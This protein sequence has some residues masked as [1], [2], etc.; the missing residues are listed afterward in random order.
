MGFFSRITRPLSNIISGIGSG[1]EDLGGSVKKW[2]GLDFEE[3]DTAQ[4]QISGILLNK[5]SATAKIPIV[6]G[7]RRVG[8]TRVFLHTQG[9]KNSQLYTVLVLSEGQV[10]RISDIEIN[11]EPLNNYGTVT[12]SVNGANYYF[13]VSGVARIAAVVGAWDQV[14]D[15][16]FVTD[17]SSQ[18]LWT[19]EHRLAGVAALLSRYTY[20]AEHLSRMP[21]ATAVV[22]G[23]VY[24]VRSSSYVASANAALVIYDYMKNGVYGEAVPD[25]EINLASFKKA[26][27]DADRVAFNYIGADET[28]RPLDINGV[29]S[30]DKS[31][32]DNIKILLSH[33]RASLPYVAG[34][35][36]LI[37]R[38]QTAASFEFTND[39]IMGDI[40]VAPAN[41]AS[42][43]NRVTV[44]YVDPALFW[45]KSTVTYPIDDA[46]YQQLLSEDNGIEK[47]DEITADMIT[48]KYQ[49]LDFARQYL[50]ESRKS[51][52][53]SFK[54][55][56]S[57]RK[58][59]PGAVVS[60]N[61]AELGSFLFTVEKRVITRDGEYTF[62]LKEY[63]PSTYS[64]IN[65]S[66]IVTGETP[67]LPT[68]YNLPPVTNLTF[69][70]MAYN[71]EFQGV[72]Q[73]E[74]SDSAFV[75][76]YQVQVFN[77]VTAALVWSALVQVD[78]VQVPNF[79]AGT[80]RA[81]I[82]GFSDL[83][84]T[85]LVT[86]EW[87]YSVPVL[88]IVTGLKQ[89]GT[90]DTALS[91][92]WDAI[93]DKQA[94]RDYQ[95]SLINPDSDLVIFTENVLSETITIP[96]SV[97]ET[98]GF[99][100]H[101]EVQVSATNVALSHGPGASLIVDKPAPLAAL[102]VSF[103]PG[104]N[105][106]EVRVLLSSGSKGVQAWLDTALPVPQDADHIVYQGE[107]G[108]FNVLGL[109]E[110]TQ[111]RL[112][113]ACYDA[114][115][116]GVV[117][118]HSVTTL[119]DGVAASIQQL[120]EREL[121]LG[122]DVV[123]LAQLAQENATKAQVN[124]EAV[125]E[126]VLSAAVESARSARVQLAQN[127][128]YYR[129]LNAVVEV[130]PSTGTITNRAYEY[131]NGKFSEAVVLIDGANAAI[132]LQS[133]RI[134]TTETAIESANSQLSVLAGEINQRATFA[135]VNEAVVGAI[136]AVQPSYVTNFYSG[137]DGWEVLA[138]T[139][140]FNPGQYLDLTL[141]DI[142]TA[143][144]YDGAENPVIQLVLSRDVSAVW[145][146]VVQ[147]QTAG[148]GYS[149]E[150]Q[151][152]IDEIN[153][154]GAQYTVTV[155]FS[156]VPDYT[157]NMITGLHIV[158][159]ASVSD[160]FTLHSVQAGKKTAAQIA[161]DGL[162]GR[163]TDAEQS[164]N[165]VTGTL[166]QYV[167]TT[168][169]NANAMTQSSVSNILDSW[170]NTHQVLATLTE[171][172]SAG[173]ISK[174]NAASTWISGADAY[175]KNLASSVMDNGVGQDIIEVKQT[176]DAQAGV[177]SGQVISITQAKHAV[178]DA[179]E[180]L[181]LA[182]VAQASADRGQMMQSDSLALAKQEIKATSDE[183]N[184][185]AVSVSELVAQVAGNQA[186]V[187]EYQRA[188]IGF[189]VDSEGNPTSHETAAACE[190]VAGNTWQTSTIAEAVKNVTITASDTDGNP[191]KVTAGSLYQAIVDAEGH[192]TAT[193][194]LMAALNGQLAGVFANVG[195]S[196]SE[197]V[198]LADR[199]EF[200]T[201]NG[202][203][204]PFQIEGETLTAKDLIVK[205]VNI[206][207]AAIGS[208]Q[209]SDLESTGYIPG[210]EG[211][212]IYKDGS[213]EF[214]GPVISR[215]LSV[216]EGVYDVGNVS[217]SNQSSITKLK[218]V[219]I[220]T[221]YSGVSWAGTS[222]Y[223]TAD[224]G[225][226]SSSVNANVSTLA[227]AKWAVNCEVLPVTRWNAT[228][229]GPTVHL[230]IRIWG[231]RINYINPCKI[232]WRLLRVS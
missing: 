213:A 193:A 150:Y 95:V 134:T 4:T 57:A 56:P 149:S 229:G 28:Y 66:E 159:G 116:L 89:V 5:A 215:E 230:I 47:H 72:L 76:R 113:V 64:W 31:R 189:C 147:Y 111:Y 130:D 75:T 23:R 97:F 188:A 173:T 19:N 185:L 63:D 88:P 55:L 186:S 22:Q 225:F 96:F 125:A 146:G 14:A 78:N 70:P 209:I 9:S 44:T 85:E 152:P 51:L 42:K 201:E 163:V 65:P 80:Y 101:F 204:T 25:D 48:S 184:A 1:L 131:T 169:Y 29:V 71:T 120:T 99:P 219:V 58:V 82:K 38:T 33:A 93:S 107:T 100:R 86:V 132:N 110:L 115:G 137:L 168:W 90:F 142:A 158:L 77:T 140:V 16:D 94:L 177:L 203:L 108:R 175:I 118:N 191:V 84:A 46:E 216:L 161:L 104:H 211:W 15:A 181:L 192:A 155:D 49:A 205:T 83:S 227:E 117:S 212:K 228:Y 166:E 30:T 206:D 91:L 59:L 73:W 39:H 18:G 221:G 53:V 127:D 68:P 160:R 87:A 45:E 34:Q 74:E 36:H 103:L 154:D 6:Y 17:L 61:V 195:V 183:Q 124:Q 62:S 162:Q 106:F 196:G 10:N 218:E 170:N 43:C 190:L 194:A 231:Q 79:P 37:I 208:A 129:I 3:A 148:H 40:S 210:Q 222:F 232:K 114:F 179:E 182:G 217:A 167:T 119:H 151:L 27:D 224:A 12:D 123:T 122:N 98:L 126:A 214:N 138:G 200:K 26:A 92:A 35:Y 54:A 153:A 141:G 226:T 121:S 143:L 198:F 8:G 60:V 20:N 81:E 13:N 50:L 24:D 128:E 171:L 21:V 41:A 156:G 223:I 11:D 207:A 172:N 139:A 7:T 2:L 165:A 174:A 133:Q 176:L 199:F 105:Q 135:Q 202:T 178:N 145:A 157:N 164:I 67:T 197:L 220:D 102:S 109:T 180:A 112:A 69:S 144:S 187:E 136:D 52:T 32:L